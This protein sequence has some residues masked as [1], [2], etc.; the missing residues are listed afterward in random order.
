MNGNYYREH[1]TR[2]HHEGRP[3][4]IR[5]LMDTEC[6]KNNISIGVPVVRGNV[7]VRTLAK[8]TKLSEADP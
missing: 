5:E 7:F 3:E 8:Y 2:H 4:F 6:V 1:R